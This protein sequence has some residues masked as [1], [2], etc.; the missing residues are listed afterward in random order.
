MSTTALASGQCCVT[1]YCVR[2]SALRDTRR[3]GSAARRTRRG[4]PP[5]RRTASS[6]GRLWRTSAD[7]A[8]RPLVRSEAPGSP[9][10]SS[11]SSRS[12]RGSTP[13]CMNHCCTGGLLAMHVATT[14]AARH[15]RLGWSQSSRSSSVG[16]PPTL[17]RSRAK[18][19]ED[20]MSS[21]S[22]SSSSLSSR[23]S[24]CAGGGG[25]ADSLAAAPAAGGCSARTPVSSDAL[26][27]FMRA[28]KSC[29]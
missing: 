17:C 20:T 2:L 25:G 9:A 12:R 21:S 18:S 29:M 28:P 6:P 22:S 23:L 7:T 27:S 13:P 10:P 3:S 16:S 8:S 24:R 14:S 4:S 19:M 15:L 26:I 11:S 5:A 1:T